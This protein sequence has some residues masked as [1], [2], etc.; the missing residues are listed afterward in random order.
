MT[1][2][3]QIVIDFYSKE[4]LCLLFRESKVIVSIPKH[5]T[6]AFALINQHPIDYEPLIG[7]YD[8]AV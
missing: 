7:C 8:M 6:L 1:R 5:Y 2:K 3:V 4:R